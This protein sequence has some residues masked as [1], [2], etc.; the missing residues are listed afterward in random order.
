MASFGYVP[1]AFG[2][3]NVERGYENHDNED[4]VDM[5]LLTDGNKKY[6]FDYKQL[7]SEYATVFATPP[8]ITLSRDKKLVVTPI[9]NS[10]DIEVVERYNTNPYDINMKGL[11]IDMEEHD[12]PID[13]MKEL[14]EIF[15]KNICWDVTCPF[16]NKMGIMALYIK[17]VSVEMVEGFADTVSYE[18]NAKAIKPLSYQLI[19]Q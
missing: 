3:L 15:E 8:M 7:E 12:F 6:L 5:M 17:D 13:K 1:S 19:N 11:I 14:N 2:E 4:T 9:D 16:L 18:M 10:N